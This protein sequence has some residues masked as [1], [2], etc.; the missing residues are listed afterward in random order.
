MI[1]KDDLYIVSRGRG[2]DVVQSEYQVSGDS[3]SITQDPQ[4]LMMLI[5]IPYP[6]FEDQV[7]M[8]TRLRGSRRP[9]SHWRSDY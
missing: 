9:P 4:D 1:V 8:E 5:I 7:R 3:T 6:F 2:L